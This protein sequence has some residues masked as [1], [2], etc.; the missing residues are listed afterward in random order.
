MDDFVLEEASY[1]EAL[2]MGLDRDDPIVRQ[3]LRQKVEFLTLSE[4]KASELTV[5]ALIILVRSTMLT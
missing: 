5:T 2:A 1:R 4:L 3:R